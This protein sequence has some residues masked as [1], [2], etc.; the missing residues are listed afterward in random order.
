METYEGKVKTWDGHK[1]KINE[2]G[3]EKIDP[4]NHPSHYETGKFECIEVMTE[5][6]GEDAVLK[7]CLCNAFKY[8]Y[9]AK[10]K[11]GFEDIQKAR[12]YLNKWADIVNNVQSEPD[13]EHNGFKV[14]T[15]EL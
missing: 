2:D 13:A 3:V 10:R 5:A 7:F 11:N 14:A 8:L 4:V 12:W 15:I 9:R 1:L 6:L